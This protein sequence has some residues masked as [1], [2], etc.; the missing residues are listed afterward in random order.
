MRIVA[1]TGVFDVIH[2]GHLLYLREAAK[3]GDRL[4]V[5]VAS[6][7]TVK[8]RKKREAIPQKQRLEVVR[9]LKPV[10]DAVLGDDSDWYKTLREINPDILALGYDQDFDEKQLEEKLRENNVNAQVSRIMASWSG[11]YNSSKVIRGHHEKQ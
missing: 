2:P 9:S 11:R 4:V 10:D 5:V 7:A 8:K 3:L 6:D 1:A